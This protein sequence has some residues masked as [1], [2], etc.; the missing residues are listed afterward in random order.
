ME[1]D[2]Y[3]IFSYDDFTSSGLVQQT[4]EPLLDERG[5]VTILITR[6]N[7]IGV[8]IDDV[9]LPIEFLDNNPYVREGYAVYRDGDD[10]WLGFEVET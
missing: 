9:F 10:V 8:Q 4:I 3:R 6:G 2:W 1:F 7:T 5:L